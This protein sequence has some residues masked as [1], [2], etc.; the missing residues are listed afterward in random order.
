MLKEELVRI[1]AENSFSDKMNVLLKILN[2]L[3]CFLV[4]IC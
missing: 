1:N 3:I 2:I 4:I